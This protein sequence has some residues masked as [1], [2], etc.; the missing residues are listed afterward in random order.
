MLHI[1]ALAAGCIDGY[2][3]RHWRAP[4]PLRWGA[5]GRIADVSCVVRVQ[6]K[7]EYL[8][9]A[10]RSSCATDGCLAL[11]DDFVAG[12]CNGLFAKRSTIEWRTATRLEGRPKASRIRRPTTS[13]AARGST[14]PRAITVTT[15]PVE[16]GEGPLLGWARPRGRLAAWV[17]DGGEFLYDQGSC[18]GAAARRCERRRPGDGARLVSPM[19]DVP[20]A[21]RVS[22]MACCTRRRCR[23]SP[24]AACRIF[25]ITAHVDL[26]C[27]GSST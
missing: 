6:W 27:S 12:T 24:P 5:V 15:K 8:N 3:A 22:P 10:Q 18:N 25:F 13:M 7:T 20:L 11:C 14:M 4:W 21:A 23:S 9:G 17:D 19:Q 1:L 2:L 16:A 26:A